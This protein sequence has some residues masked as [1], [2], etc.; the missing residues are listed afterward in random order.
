MMPLEWRCAECGRL[1]SGGDELRTHVWR[2]HAHALIARHPWLIEALWLLYRK[3]ELERALLEDRG[4]AA[5]SRWL[6]KARARRDRGGEADLIVRAVRNERAAALRLYRT[7]DS[8][9]LALLVTAFEIDRGFAEQERTTAFCDDRLA[10]IERVLRGGSVGRAALHHA[11]HRHG[12][13]ER[14]LGFEDFADRRLLIAARLHDLE[15]HLRERDRGR[16]DALVGA[17]L[18]RVERVV[19][20]TASTLPVFTPPAMGR[21]PLAVAGEAGVDVV[22]PAPGRRAEVG[23]QRVEEGDDRLAVGDVEQRGD[24]LEAPWRVEADEEYASSTRCLTT[25]SRGCSKARNMR[26]SRPGRPGRGWWSGGSFSIGRAPPAPG[27]AALIHRRLAR[28][29]PSNPPGR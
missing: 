23:G 28:V 11:A 1:T 19:T 14:R 20:I 15:R 10:L 29:V 13:I 5:M 21:L 16:L 22:A 17:L 25:W 7:C 12:A 26:G 9:S 2:E 27:T 8:A 3:Q 6:T 24:G 4:A 18:L